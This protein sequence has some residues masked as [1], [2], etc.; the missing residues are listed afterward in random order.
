MFALAQQLTIRNVNDQFK[1]WK[2][3]QNLKRQKW[4]EKKLLLLR[5]HL[6]SGK[7]Q[8]LDGRLSTYLGRGGERPN[9]ELIH[10]ERFCY[11][12]KPI[13]LE[14]RLFFSEKCKKWM[15]TV[16]P[17]WAIFRMILA[18]NFLTQ[19][20][21]PF[22]DFWCNF[23]MHQ[24]RIKLPPWQ[25]LWP[26]FGQIFILTSGHTDGE[27]WIDLLFPLLNV[28]DPIRFRTNA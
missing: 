14:L 9:K 1:G 8:W 26:T 20:A 24:F 13:Q 10:G 23:K 25:L 11:F 16:W 15:R 22:G 28:I 2:N 17:D 5:H 18:S 21:Q 7:S 12:D 6:H 4:A 27:T 3:N 19:V